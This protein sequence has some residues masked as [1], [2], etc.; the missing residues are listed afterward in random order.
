MVSVRLDKDLEEK[1][2]ILAKELNVSKST[3]I[4]E[5][6]KEYMKSK[7]PYELGKDFFGKYGGDEN[8]SVNY[9]KILKEKLYGKSN[10]R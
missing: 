7:T 1:L 3:I 9:K 5:A 2:E 8:L 6:L 10:N 4:K